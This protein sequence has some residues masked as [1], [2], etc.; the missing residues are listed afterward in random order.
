M[1]KGLKLP[2]D[3]VFHKKIGIQSNAT[4][5]AKDLFKEIKKQMKK[6][7]KR[8][9]FVLDTKIWEPIFSDVAGLPVT[10]TIKNKKSGVFYV[11]LEKTC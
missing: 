2:D 7:D 1:R 4:G 3:L 11:P 6:K 9:F 5:Q 8:D 10:I